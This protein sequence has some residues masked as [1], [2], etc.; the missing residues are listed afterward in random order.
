MRIYNEVDMR[1]WPSSDGDRDGRVRLMTDW[2]TDSGH[3]YI[4]VWV[5]LVYGIH[6]TLIFTTLMK[7][8]DNNWLL[9]F[10][11]RWLSRFHQ[12]LAV[13]QL[14][15]SP[16]CNVEARLSNPANWLNKYRRWWWPRHALWLWFIANLHFFVSRFFIVRLSAI[17]VAIDSMAQKNKPDNDVW[18]CQV[19]YCTPVSS[20][21]YA[22]QFYA[23][24]NPYVISVPIL[25]FKKS[26]ASPKNT[27]NLMT[28]MMIPLPLKGYYI[29]TSDF[30]ISLYS[31]HD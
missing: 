7:K 11:F 29:I 28:I 23:L 22:P 17:S 9:K 4:C 20:P 27:N 25:I 21:F 6:F 14:V 3:M 5:T 26:S 12:C 2:L 8:I 15:L 1:L 13:S 24:K 19:R 16:V 18:T 10:P 30:L 31:E